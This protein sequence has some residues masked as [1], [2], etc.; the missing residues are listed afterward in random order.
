[1]IF[2]FF[3]KKCTHEKIGY[4]TE[5]GYCPDCGEYV[6][7]KWYLVRCSCCG[8][9][10]AAI[11]KGNEILPAFHR[12]SNC[13]EEGYYIEPLKKL[14]LVDINFATAVKITPMTQKEDFVQVWVKNNLNNLKLLQAP[15]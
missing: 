12:C 1:M 15:A 6:E 7:T 11:T 8:I 14:N 9:K 3:T 5:C 10:R 4:N 13:G 2:S